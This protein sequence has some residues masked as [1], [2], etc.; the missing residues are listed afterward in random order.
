[1]SWRPVRPVAAL[2]AEVLYRLGHHD[3]ALEWTERSGRA[4]PPEDVEA[5]AFWRTTR[6]K[7]VAT[8]GEADEALRLSSEAIDWIRRSDGLHA[9]GTCLSDRAEI[10]RLLGRPDEARPFLEEALG[11]YE[12]KGIVP[13]IESTRALLAQ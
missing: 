11:V 7:I 2:L 10:H 12:H 3:E 5:Q 8:R 9:I 1:M 6:A 4:T 13:S